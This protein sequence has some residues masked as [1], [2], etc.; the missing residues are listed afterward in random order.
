MRSRCSFESPREFSH[1]DNDPGMRPGSD[2][3]GA[4]G[5]SHGELDL[6]PVDFRYLSLPGDQASN[7]RRREM[8]SV[9]GRADR[10]LTGIEIGSDCIEGS[11][12][13]DHDHHGGSEH[14]RQDRVLEPVRKM[15]GLHEKAEGALGSKG[16]LPHGL[17]SKGRGYEHDGPSLVP[18][19][20]RLARRPCEQCYAA[21][22]HLFCDSGAEKLHD[23]RQI[24]LDAH[25]VV[26]NLDPAGDPLPHCRRDKVQGIPFPVVIE[27]AEKRAELGPQ[28]ADA[29]V[30][31]APR[32]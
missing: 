4:L 16:Y 30:K 31:P 12:F 28:P 9:D 24:Y 27:P 2:L 11:V 18:W 1:V 22:A 15:L 5:C 20:L 7:G 26:Q 21:A 10:A 6:A 23:P 17:S 29:A 3:L 8:A 19:L 25:D 13:H 14:W 32:L